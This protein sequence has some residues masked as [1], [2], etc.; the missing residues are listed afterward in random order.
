MT[1]LLTSELEELPPGDAR[2]RA[3]LLLPGGAVRSNDEIRVF[4]E[5]A[6][7]ESEGLPE[8]RAAVLA[9][10]STNEA[11]IRVERI[12]DAVAWAEEA[13]AMVRRLGPEVQR[14]ALYTL[15][16]ARSLRG[17]SIQDLRSRFAAVSDD[18]SY[19]LGSP[20]RVAAQQLVWRG[21]LDEARVVL[22]EPPVRRGRTGRAGLVRSGAAASV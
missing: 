18:A 5:R 15:A 19:I 11:V 9:N 7:V 13:L 2:V 1:D 14:W 3:C 22:S 16:W 20:E 10:M 6:L 8:A 21:S 4:L 12:A 17:R